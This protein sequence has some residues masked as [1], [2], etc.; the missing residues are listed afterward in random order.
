M[1]ITDPQAIRFCNEA[2]RPLCERVRALKADVDALGIEWFGG[3]SSLFPNDSSVVE[4]GRTAE[5]VS[6]LTGAD[7]TNAI[8]QFLAFQTQLNQAG[9]AGVISKPCVRLLV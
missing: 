8:T 1:P 7:V 2:I 3:L 9:V 6:R 5:G 4:D